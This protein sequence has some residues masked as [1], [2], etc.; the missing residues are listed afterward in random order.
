MKKYLK[1]LFFIV[2]PFGWLLYI[3]FHKNLRKILIQKVTRFFR[4]NIQA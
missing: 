3:L 1:M 4:G 2:V